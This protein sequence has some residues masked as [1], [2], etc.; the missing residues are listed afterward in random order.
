MIEILRVGTHTSAEGSALTF[1]ADDLR[2]IAV[3]YDPRFHRAPLVI[4]HPKDNDPAWGWVTTLVVRDGVLRAA[5]DQV[6]PA[7]KELVDA[8]RYGKVSASL[9]RPD[10]PQNPTPGQWHLRHV[11]FLG[12]VP[13]AIKGLAPI[14]LNAGDEGVVS[15]VSAPPAKEHTMTQNFAEREVELARREAELAERERK[16]RRR[17]N[18]AFCEGLAK[19][20]RLPPAHKPGVLELMDHVDATKTVEFAEGAG[21]ARRT[22]LDQLKQVLGALPRCIEFRE[23]AALGD[24]PPIEGGDPVAIARQAATCREEQA[25]AGNRLSAAEAVRH[26]VG[27]RG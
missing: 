4:G 5:V 16:A 22:V 25:K 26:V 18:E 21:K 27:D 17:E 6:E 9:Y 15:L 20:G 3:G 7:F 23:L 12:A 8:G 1:S 13:P 19:D 14:Q 10:A 24:N 11:G 2:A